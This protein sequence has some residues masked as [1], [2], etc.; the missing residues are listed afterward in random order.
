MQIAGVWV[1]TVRA[2]DVES[3]VQWYR[4]VLG[5]W[6]PDEE[7]GFAAALEAGDHRL[8]FDPDADADVVL[9][10]QVGDVD[11]AVDELRAAGRDVTDPVVLP[12]GRAVEL[13]DPAGI[14]L[15]LAEV[16]PTG[17][18][19]RIEAQLS[20]F[21]A[22]QADLPGS[23]TEQL[24]AD[25]AAVVEQAQQRIREVMAGVAHNKVLATQLLVSQQAR[26]AEQGSA[27]QW[28]LF[29]AS[30]LLSDLVVAG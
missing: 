4:D 7:D 20:E 29:A 21:I 12:W 27:E 10:L 6:P 15:R 30:T 17:A 1:T 3:S 28:R 9:S 18:A 25:V 23:P 2:D 19:E 8:V 11:A 14:P 26:R 5:L 24:A 22:G 16:A 13:R